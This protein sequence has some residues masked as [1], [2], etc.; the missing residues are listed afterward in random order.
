MMMMIMIIII[1]SLDAVVLLLNMECHVTCGHPVCESC[2]RQRK[3]RSV[4]VSNTYFLRFM[5]RNMR[6]VSTNTNC[7]LY[8]L[9]SNGGVLVSVS[10]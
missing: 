1:K 3:C 2:I 5:R 4:Y 10:D 8:F 7:I 6:N 9:M